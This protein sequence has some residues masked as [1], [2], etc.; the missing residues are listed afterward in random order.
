[1]AERGFL[2][3]MPKVGSELNREGGLSVEES[4]ESEPGYWETL[5]DDGFE[6]TVSSDITD[7]TT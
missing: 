1:M 6:R 3:C 7:D 5:L 2:F 4:L